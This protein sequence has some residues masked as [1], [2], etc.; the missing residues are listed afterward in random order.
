MKE[1]LELV[2]EKSMLK[3]RRVVA[4]YLNAYNGLRPWA[5]AA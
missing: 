3:Q 2:E 5:Y 4:T 1:L